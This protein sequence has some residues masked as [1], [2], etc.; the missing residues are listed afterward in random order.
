MIYFDA[1]IPILIFKKLNSFRIN[2][3]GF[4]SRQHFEE[5]F[6]SLLL[7]ISKENDVN[8]VGEFNFLKTKTAKYYDCKLKW[9]VISY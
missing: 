3:F 9:R 4:S 8:I 5:F 1:M 2:I 7:L 6:M